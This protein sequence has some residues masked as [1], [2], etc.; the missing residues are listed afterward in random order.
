MHTILKYTNLHWTYQAT[1]L[2]LWSWLD[3]LLD[4]QQ[5]STQMFPKFIFMT[6]GSQSI[7]LWVD[8]IAF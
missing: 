3:P 2:Y 8:S 1:Q 6:K 7:T 5:Y 4:L